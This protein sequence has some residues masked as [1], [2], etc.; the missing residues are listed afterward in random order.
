M[1]LVHDIMHAAERLGL[2]VERGGASGVIDGRR[3]K[4][5]VSFPYTN[6]QSV[7]VRGQ[8]EWPLD[9]GVHVAKAVRS[10]FGEGPIRIGHPDL[11]GE[12]TVLGDEPARVRMLL[13]GAI[14]DALVAL[15]RA[16]FEVSLDDGGCT[17]YQFVGFDVPDQAWLE[18][19]LHGAAKIASLMEEA[20]ARLPPAKPIEQH[21]AAVHGVAKSRGLAFSTTPVLATGDFDGCPLE[22]GTKR[23]DVRTHH[24]FARARIETS[25][26]VGL[27]VRR[28]GVL[29]SV[30]SLLGGQDI[31]LGDPPFDKHF[32]V[33][34]E[35]PAQVP[36]LL[37]RFARS[38]LLSIDE[39]YGP[40]TVDDETVSV[41]PIPLSI[42]LDT[43]IILAELLTEAALR[44]SSNRVHGGAEGGPYR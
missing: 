9:L 7:N 41:E 22:I 29:D 21:A 4:V 24:L 37:D 10:P 17:I 1:A 35:R 3:V 8:L 19:A 38:H 26:G 40:V 15:Y 23:T 33:R 43:V 11:D 5:W 12:L 32:L 42:Q 2:T 28:Q 25:L 27:A 16:A 18:R 14:A 36:V 13:D 20:R 31:V 44:L 34:A 30:R 6:R 39:H